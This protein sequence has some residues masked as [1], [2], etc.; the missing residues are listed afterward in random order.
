MYQK[1]KIK[2]NK[3]E[4]EKYAQKSGIKFIVLFGSQTK[5]IIKKDS[6]FDIAVLTTPEKDIRNNLDNYTRILFGLSEILNIPDF[7][8]D[9]TNLNNANI[10]LRYNIISAGELLYGDKTEYEELKAF[11]FRDYI[12]AKPLFNLESLLIHKRQG[13]IAKALG[14]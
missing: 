14:Q 6:D 2:F 5:G 1:E 4:L 11:A 8:M 10:L 9:L 7:K 3:I 13:L 12:D